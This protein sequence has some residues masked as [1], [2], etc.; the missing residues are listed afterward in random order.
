MQKIISRWF[1]FGL[2]LGWALMLGWSKPWLERFSFGP[3]E[4]AWRSLTYG[5][6]APFRRVPMA[7]A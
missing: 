6:P 2:L 7:S 3:L 1:M 4:W 5:I